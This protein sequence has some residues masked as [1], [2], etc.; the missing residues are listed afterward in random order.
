MEPY[1]DYQ[2]WSQPKILLVKQACSVRNRVALRLR[3]WL[4][5]GCVD[6][7]R[8]TYCQPASPNPSSF[9]HQGG[10][11]FHFATWDRVCCPERVG[12]LGTNSEIPGV[13]RIEGIFSLV[14]SC[15]V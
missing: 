13:H 10:H 5:S 8:L 3:P 1:H 4:A 14:A 11:Y 2:V 7:C 6:H 15:T 12:F 9:K